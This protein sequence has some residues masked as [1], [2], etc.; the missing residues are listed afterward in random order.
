MLLG[1]GP[2]RWAS[3]EGVF[4]FQVPEE[5]SILST[6][7]IMLLSSS[8]YAISIFFDKGEIKFDEDNLTIISLNFHPPHTME[9]SNNEKEGG[10]VISFSWF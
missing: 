5:G 4:L 9:D 1:S 6:E 7:I 8:L 3:S 2:T 10:Y